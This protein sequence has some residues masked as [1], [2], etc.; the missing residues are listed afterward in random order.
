MTLEELRAKAAA[1]HAKSQAILAGAQAAGR[2]LTADEARIIDSNTTDFNATMADV[3]RQVIVEAQA[4]ALA[5]PQARITSD[6]T[7]ATVVPVTAATTSTRQVITAAD[8]SGTWGFKHIGD[9]LNSVKNARNG[10]IDP[11][12]V[13]NAV[14][15]YSGEGTN[16]D[17]GYAL[18]PDF[19]AG[20]TK[21]LDTPE[22][23]F[24]KLD[25]L[26]TPNYTVTLPIDE[27]PPWS[28]SG[29]A[30]AQV[31]EGASLTPVKPVLKQL[32]ISLVKYGDL[33]FVTEE[34]LADGTLIGPYIQRK[35]ADKIGWK[36]T[37]AV[38]AALLGSSGRKTSSK[39]STGAGLPATL[40]NLQTMQVDSSVGGFAQRGIWLAN[41]AYMPV[42]QGLTIGN[43]P[44][45]L[46][47]GGLS[48]TPYGT[49]WGRPVMY[50]E[51][52]S[53]IGTEGDIMFVVPDQVFGVSKSDGLRADTSIHFAFDQD[54]TAFRFYVRAAIKHKWSAVITRPDTTT[55]SSIVT[56]AAR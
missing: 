40:A 35:C 45:Y 43:W 30:A 48:A 19:R 5:K 47:P 44:A 21:L 55:A 51:A 31:A 14:S 13:K 39:G 7:N 20:V 42:L 9:F 3:D 26:T 36:L 8:D 33:A 50:S 29:L 24:P 27:D 22:A 1:I 28:A 32:A 34:M 25:Q 18:P 23:L 56:L 54:M 6:V 37:A 12:F 17:G 41:P 38:Y 46:P 2:S 4:A 49:L 10:H 11:R 52:C 15:T 53:A 16:A